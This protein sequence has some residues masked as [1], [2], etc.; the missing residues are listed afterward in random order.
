MLLE[1]TEVMMTART[2]EDRAG[3]AIFCAGAA[4]AAGLSVSGC[5]SRAGHDRAGKHMLLAAVGAVGSSPQ[6]VLL[7]QQGRAG[8]GL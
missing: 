3:L 4:A 8:R 6:S 1:V 7:L 2:V 5:C